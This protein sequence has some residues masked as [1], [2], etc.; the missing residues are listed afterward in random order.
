[1]RL[2]IIRHGKAEDRSP[3]RKDTSRR[4]TGAGRKAMRKAARGLREIA[5]EIDVLVTSP[6]ARARET[7]E[8]VAEALGV[9][10]IVEQKLLAPEGD[11]RA[12]I[13]WLGKQAPRST[14]AL[15][16]HEPD[17]SALAGLLVCASERP[18]IA[19]KKG[20][21]YL[22]EFSHGPAAGK[23]MLLWLLQPSQLRKIGT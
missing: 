18:R 1:V 12:L 5:P 15:V 8:I 20:A 9:G 14:V 11:K 19:L 4:L 13:A 2:L 7:A 3:K 21:C 16:G 6:L 10:R 17:L 23:G 22:I